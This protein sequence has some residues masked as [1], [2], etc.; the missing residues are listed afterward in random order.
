V[1]Y[2]EREP[3]TE[4]RM[5]DPKKPWPPRFPPAP[6]GRDGRTLTE[7]EADDWGRPTFDSYLVQTCHALRHKPLGTLTVEDLRILIGQK[8]SVPVLIPLALDRLEEDVLARGDFFPGDLLKN[9]LQLDASFWR[10]YPDYRRRALVLAKDALVPLESRARAAEP[11]D[12]GERVDPG[13]VRDVIR[14]FLKST[15]AA[16]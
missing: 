5:E 2:D 9:V 6:P 4:N 15:E 13:E 3:P 11:A 8:V 16:T 1:S 7:I 12:A 10:A 14:A